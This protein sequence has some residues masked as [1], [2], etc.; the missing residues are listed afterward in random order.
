MDNIAIS[1][2]VLGCTFLIIIFIVYC[3]VCLKRES[4]DKL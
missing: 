2:V 3:I 4:Y 1:W